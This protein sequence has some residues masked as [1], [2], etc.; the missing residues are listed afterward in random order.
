[1]KICIVAGADRTGK[2]TLCEEF[3][4]AGWAY[5][6]FEK[7][8][9]SPF[10]EYAKF[11]TEKLP[12]MPADSKVIV[13][14]FSYCELAYSKHYGRK[15]DL[16]AQKTAWLEDE[17]LRLDP[18]AKVVYCSTD[19]WSNWQRIEDEGKGEFKSMTELVELRKTYEAA[20]KWSHLG[21]IRYDFTAGD[22]PAAVLAACEYCIA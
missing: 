9:G 6:H 22:E 1:M 13:D 20:I 5:F 16:D 15:S 21:V 4:K 17:I 18:S 19:L 3:K 12:S 11:V 8:K 10:E 7:P 2:S 14:R